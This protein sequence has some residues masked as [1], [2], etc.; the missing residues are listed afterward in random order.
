MARKKANIHYLYKTTCLITNR[1]YIGMHSTTNLEDGYLGSGL[2]LRRSIRKHGEDNH[3]KEI[4][5]FFET[6]ELLIEGEKKAITS[7][8]VDDVNCMNLKLGGTGGFSVENAKKGREKTDEVLREKYG[9]N[10][11]QII[12]K[13][14]H[15]SL[16]DDEKNKRSKNIIE[17]QIKI[18]YN[19]NT[20]EGKQHSEETKQLM[21]E[22]FKD[23]GTGKTNS[24]YGTCWITKEGGNK[25]IKKENLDSFIKDGWVKGRKINIMK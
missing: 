22:L 7:E 1:Y 24:Q 8:M 5:D 18:N 19:H 9:D 6:R 10:F 3:K 25:K 11:K 20:F 17:G 12:S 15:N 14:Y 2:R 13:N 16:T 23:K 21:R 4:L